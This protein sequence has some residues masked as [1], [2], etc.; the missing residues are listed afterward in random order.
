MTEAAPS[1]G[2][3]RFEAAK[4]RDVDQ[5]VRLH[6]TEAKV[7]KQRSSSGGIACRQKLGTPPPGEQRAKAAAARMTAPVAEHRRLGDEEVTG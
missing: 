3:H 2:Q 1:A 7:H 6:S 4:H 5:W